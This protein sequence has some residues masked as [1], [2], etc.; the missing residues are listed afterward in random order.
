MRSRPVPRPSPPADSPIH[1]SVVLPQRGEHGFRLPFPVYTASVFRLLNAA[2]IVEMM[3]PEIAAARPSAQIAVWRACGVAIGT[4]WH[5]STV[6]LE[7][8]IATYG[9]DM[10][11]YGL[12]VMEELH[13]AGYGGSEIRDLHN[14]VIRQMTASLHRGTEV[15]ARKGFFSR[16]LVTTS[17]SPSTSDSTSSE[18]DPSPTTSSPPRSRLISWLTGASKQTG[19]AP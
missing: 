7:T 2:G 3:D 4:A 14:T 9:D 16:P 5:H 17:S 13:E 19:T 1:F 10:D 12:A 15:D 11:A 8:D 6:D 18:A